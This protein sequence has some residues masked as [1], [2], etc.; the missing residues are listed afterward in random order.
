MEKGM[1]KGKIEI[2]INLKKSGMTSDKIAEITGLNKNV[3]DKM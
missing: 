2:A 3:I 1:E